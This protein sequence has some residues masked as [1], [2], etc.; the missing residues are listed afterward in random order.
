MTLCRPHRGSC[1]SAA[2]RLLLACAALSACHRAPNP[3]YLAA[4]AE[5]QNRIE[6]YRGAQ[7]TTR[8]IPQRLQTLIDDNPAQPH[9][10]A[11]AAHY[12]IFVGSANGWPGRSAKS[13]EAAESLLDDAQKADA[14]Y[15]ATYWLRAQ[16]HAA[17]KQPD[18][19]I[20]VVDMAIGRHCDDPWLHVSRGNALMQK[21]QLDAD[22]VAKPEL[23]EAVA[24]YRKIVDAGPGAS[25]HSRS[26][27]A[28]AANDLG[29]LL[30]RTGRHDE[31]RE[32]LSRWEAAGLV[33]DPWTQINL[34]Y[35]FD[36]IGKFDHAQ[37]A[38]QSALTVFDIPAARKVLGLSLYG[39][40][41]T[42]EAAGESNAASVAT[43]TAKAHE[44]V[45]DEAIAV[46]AFANEACCVSESWKAVLE[47]HASGHVLNVA[48][49]PSH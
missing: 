46:S 24:E 5:I 45:P 38:A 37:I 6:D 13:P 3:E 22:D 21:V 2:G 9:A 7:S 47:T 4:I 31:L 1:F 48:P 26:A 32:H 30:Y 34:S 36:L 44:Y 11:E 49:A 18:R 25:G 33:F 27:Y 42:L 14:G 17:M 39:Q 20:A 40:A 19:A 15:C 41:W 10:Y 28:N 35:Q 29:M 12:L 16:L 43:L 23:A 8:D